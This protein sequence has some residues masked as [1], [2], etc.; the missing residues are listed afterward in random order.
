MGDTDEWPV[1]KLVAYLA[2]AEGITQEEIT[3]LRDIPAFP[4]EMMLGEAYTNR[5]KYM[6]RQLYPPAEEFRIM[7][8]PI[9]DWGQTKWWHEMD[10]GSYA[11]VYKSARAL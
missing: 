5:P 9:L 7:E 10:E 6:A 2:S 1:T 11:L 3:H 8:L 4:K